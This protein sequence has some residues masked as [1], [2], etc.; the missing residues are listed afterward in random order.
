LAIS[1]YTLLHHLQGV[2][3]DSYLDLVVEFLNG[4]KETFHRDEE[5]IKR[6]KEDEDEIVE[7]LQ[8]LTIEEDEWEEKFRKLKTKMFNAEHEKEAMEIR[9]KDLQRELD[10]TKLA[11]SQSFSEN[12]LTRPRRVTWADQ[13]PLKRM[14]GDGW[15]LPRS[16]SESAVLSLK[17][18]SSDAES[19]SSGGS[20][21]ALT[22]EEVNEILQM[23][24]VSEDLPH[25]GVSDVSET[26]WI[27]AK[28]DEEDMGNSSM[29]GGAAIDEDFETNLTEEL[30]IEDKV[31][32]NPDAKKLNSPKKEA[33]GTEIP[34]TPPPKS[35][36]AVG[37]SGMMQKQPHVVRN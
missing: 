8:R 13:L 29:K 28:N 34:M 10:R 26:S 20:V 23:E 15:R 22:K 14:P 32:P 12:S 25:A 21:P 36:D 4:A 31:L 35:T 1:C 16:S 2:N 24:S 30:P 19:A 33:G 9:L 37:G 3:I 11:S 7:E 27:D 17:K 18:H 5:R 6:F